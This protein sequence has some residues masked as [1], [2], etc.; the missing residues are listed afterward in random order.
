MANPSG[1]KGAAF[2][3]KVKETLTKHY[4]IQF[5]RVPY[6]G[7]L[8]YLKG[9]VWAPHH[10]HLWDYTI[11][12]KHYKEVDFNSLLSAKSNVIHTFWK[13]TIDEAAAMSKFPLLIFRWDRSKNYVVWDTI[14]DCKSQLVLSAFGWNYKIAL[15]TDWLNEN[16]QVF[17]KLK[18]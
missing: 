7:A 15:L 5:E 6:S 18:G 17:D 8:H 12:C 9:D 14:F 16:N 3:R 1:L 4:K 10:M 13:Q 11:E 2:E